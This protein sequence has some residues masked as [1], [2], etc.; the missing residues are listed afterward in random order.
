MSK[1]SLFEDFLQKQ[2]KLDT[3]NK[4]SYLQ[5]E[6]IGVNH[7]NMSLDTLLVDELILLQRYLETPWTSIDSQ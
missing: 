1:D 2:T 3:L 4:V 5:K 6:L 7:R